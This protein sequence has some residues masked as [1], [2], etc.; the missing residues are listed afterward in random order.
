MVQIKTCKFQ[1]YVCAGSS[2]DTSMQSLPEEEPVISEDIL[3]VAE[4]ADDIYKHLRESEVIIYFFFFL[5]S[6]LSSPCLLD[7]L[8]SLCSCGIDQSLIT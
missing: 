3:S 6:R 1:L 8:G 4:Y 5:S 2:L 7:K